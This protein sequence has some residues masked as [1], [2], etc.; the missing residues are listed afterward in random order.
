VGSIVGEAGVR[1]ALSPGGVRETRQARERA[2][3]RRFFVLVAAIWLGALAAFSLA[4]V[5]WSQPVSLV[6]FGLMTVFLFSF[7]FTFTKRLLS[8]VLP[9]SHLPAL[10]RLV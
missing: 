8:L 1:Q 2:F 6:Q 7:A 5:N 10:E 3:G 9:P 4:I